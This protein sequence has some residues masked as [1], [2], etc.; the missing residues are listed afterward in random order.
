MPLELTVTQPMEAMFTCIAT[1]R[2]R[3][4]I[5][6][7]REISGS[8][9]LV[10]NEQSISEEM[11]EISS[12]LTINP[13]SP[14]DAADYVCEASNIVNTAEMTASLTVYGEFF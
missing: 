6:W 13:T 3:P 5:Q 12:T 11:R 2:P 14:S 8:R 9:T 10:S 7:Y 1:G 4:T